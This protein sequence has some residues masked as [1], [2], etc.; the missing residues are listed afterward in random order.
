VNELYIAPS[1]LMDVPPLA[2]LQV[3][4]EAGYHGVGLRLQKSPQ[5]PIFPV[6]G[7]APLIREI[8]SSRADGGLKVLDILAF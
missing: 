6:V 7:D 3:A 8:R 2:F 5:F 1:M 4:R